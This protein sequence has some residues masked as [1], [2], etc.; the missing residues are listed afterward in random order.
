ME[1]VVPSVNGASI[2]TI[3]GLNAEP[4]EAAH[5]LLRDTREKRIGAVSA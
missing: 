2:R 3:A 4:I 1:V 5:A